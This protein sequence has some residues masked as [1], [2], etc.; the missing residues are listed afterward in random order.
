MLQLSSQT[1]DNVAQAKLQDI[2]VTIQR[3]LPD[4]DTETVLSYLKQGRAYG[5]TKRTDLIVFVECLW[6]IASSGYDMARVHRL[7]ASQELSLDHK[8]IPLRM[9]SDALAS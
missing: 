7:M 9:L 2:A 6:S 1:I 3:N 8:L 4:A 5:I